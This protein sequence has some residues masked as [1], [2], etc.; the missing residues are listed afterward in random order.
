ME[1]NNMTDRTKFSA[2]SE[3]F[4]KWHQTLWAPSSNSLVRNEI[5]TWDLNS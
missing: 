5:G 1:V 2:V 3:G 4:T